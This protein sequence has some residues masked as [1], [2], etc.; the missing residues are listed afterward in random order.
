MI[1]RSTT[2]AAIAILVSLVVHLLGLGFSADIQPEQAAGAT[3]SETLAVGNAFEDIADPVTAPVEPEQA[4]PP[5]TPVEESP[6]PDPADLPT[7]HA[8]VAS[9]DPQAVAA[10]DTGSA[11]FVQSD[12]AGQPETQDN[13]AAQPDQTA[14][15]VEPDTEVQT[16]LGE[17][18]SPAQS[19]PT[20]EED[21]EPAPADAP[22]TPQV[23]AAV[24]TPSVTTPTD[25]AD[26]DLTP[27][28]T[29]AQ[30]T[31]GSAAAVTASLRP[32]LPDSP[33]STDRSGTQDGS[34][35]FSV[36]RFPS[37]TI[38]S[39]LTAYRRDGVDRISSGNNGTQSASRG[40][41]NS[42]VT[43]YA[44]RVL[45]HLNR[46]PPVYVAAHGFARVFFEINPD[47][48]LAWVDVTDSSGSR[49]VDRAAKQQVRNAA[50]FPR[51]P[52]G[53]S[54]KLSFLYQIN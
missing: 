26:V 36:L 7:S 33:V 42:E 44:G 1:R 20:T 4:P 29:E 9:V 5:E 34:D 22:D 25:T 35:E 48:S 13:T 21:P 54:R 14:T 17:P 39:P 28:E 47:G 32:R 8:L 50:P 46:T 16:P 23:F 19:S 2:I 11:N 43:N 52:S 10:P 53:K 24:P 38:E 6:P 37:Q 40:P 49:E 15:P 27:S 45:V 12:P 3:Q 30:D 51:P 41:G 18:V 31:E